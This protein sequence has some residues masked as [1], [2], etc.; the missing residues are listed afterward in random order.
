MGLAD[1]RAH[2]GRVSESRAVLPG[3][4]TRGY[5]RLVHIGSIHSLIASPYKSAYTTAKH[6]LLGL[7][8]T[9]ALETAG[10]GYHEQYHL[11]RV[12]SHAARRCADR[13]AGPDARIAEAEVIDGVMLA[14]MPKKGFITIEEVAAAIDYLLRSP[15]P[16]VTGQDDHHRRW[17]D[18]A[19][20]FLIIL[21]ALVFLMVAAYRG[22]S[23][24][25]F[26]PI[27]ALGACC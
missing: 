9:V 23:I 1:E 11:P 2:Q 14:P 27:A 15:R 24:I 13:R 25:L 26:A 18:R 16:D 12:Y 10:Y 6:A 3:M 8:K 22:Y 5:G 20:S 7:S 21:G 19:M 17:L 4:R